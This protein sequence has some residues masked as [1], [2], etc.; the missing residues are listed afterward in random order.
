MHDTSE[1]FENKYK[2]IT[3]K[4]EDGEEAVTL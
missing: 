3:F 2:S 1:I 4:V